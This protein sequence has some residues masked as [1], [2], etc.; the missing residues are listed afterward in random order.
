MIFFYSVTIIYHLLSSSRTL[1]GSSKNPAVH[2]RAVSRNIF[3]SRWD[4]PSKCRIVPL[5]LGH[6]ATLKKPKLDEIKIMRWRSR[7]YVFALISRECN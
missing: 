4:I 3:K 2:E 6:L 5:K 7:K 1:A